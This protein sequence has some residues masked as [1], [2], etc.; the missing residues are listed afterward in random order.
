MANN[1]DHVWT[2]LRDVLELLAGAGIPTPERGYAL[3][4]GWSLA[5]SDLRR[6]VNDRNALRAQIK[7]VIAE[8]DQ[9]RAELAAAKNRALIAEKQ[10][11]R[12]RHLVCLWKDDREAQ[13]KALSAMTAERTALAAHVER[14]E[15]ALQSIWNWEMPETG[16]VWEDGTPISYAAAYGSIGERRVI[17][18]KAYAALG[19]T[20]AQSLAA[21]DAAVKVAVLWEVAEKLNG[22]GHEANDYYRQ[23]LMAE[24]DRIE[25]QAAK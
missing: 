13:A 12:S 9:L 15:K 19:S 18:Q 24:A 16:D 1:Q 6:L 21:H 10:D 20:P 17:R 23:W 25:K 2:I 14:L 22:D 4:G 11:E 8:R 5:L 7:T 3:D